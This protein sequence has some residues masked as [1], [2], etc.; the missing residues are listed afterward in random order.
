[1]VCLDVGED[2]RGDVGGGVLFLLEELSDMGGGDGG[3]FGSGGLFG[4]CAR[5]DEQG[6]E[7]EEAIEFLPGIFFVEDVGADE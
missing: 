3:E 2:G 1:M 5:D 4:G 6:G 7:G